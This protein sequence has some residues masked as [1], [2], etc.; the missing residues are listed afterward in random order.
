M[1]DM[2]AFEQRTNETRQ[3]IGKAAGGEERTSRR[4]PPGASVIHVRATHN[5]AMFAASMVF[6]YRVIVCNNGRLP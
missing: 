3:R 4:V 1:D 2:Q 6:S 5:D